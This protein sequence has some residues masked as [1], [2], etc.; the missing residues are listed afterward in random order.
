MAEDKLADWA[1]SAEGVLNSRTMP[2]VENA[3]LDVMACAI[4]G[5]ADPS[6]RAVADL[7]SRM[8]SGT[9]PTLGSRRANAAPWAAM[10]G[11]TAA[12][13]LD[14]D[15]NFAPAT[16]HA[17]A[18]LVPALFALAGEIGSSGEQLAT[19]YIVGLEIQARIGRALNPGHYESGWHATSTIG[20]IGGAGACSRLLGLNGDETLAALSAAASMASGSKKQ[21]GTMMK[22]AHAGLAAKNSV[23]A[24]RMAQAGLRGDREPIFG[25]WSL[26]E[27]YGGPRDDAFAADQIDKDLGAKLSIVEDGL[28]Q[29]RFPCCGA[30]HR[31]LDGLLALRSRHQLTIE[32]IERVDAFV[33]AFARAN[34]LYDRPKNASEARFSLTYC[35]ARILQKG[36]LTLSDLTDQSV[37]EP[38][39]QE[40]LERVH[41]QTKPGSVVEELGANAT[42]ARTRITLKNGQVIETDISHVRGSN[43]D[44]LSATETRAKF[45]DC[46]RFAG[47]TAAAPALY[48]LTG[49][50]VGAPDLRALNREFE[51]LIGEAPDAVGQAS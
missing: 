27:L 2:L 33:P 45:I 12:H 4:A 49:K 1:A 9:A 37:S 47:H 5:A 13:A 35:G 31:T 19:A 23:L 30:A 38:Q 44:P 17:S 51:A 40:W 46:C 41:V 29:K 50:I 15:D 42:P 24:A 34:L 18:V 14:F 32:A 16:T 6:A 21:F 11:G 26:S 20:V 48:E 28:L 3:L 25:A 7:C 36:D 10:A 8:G 39:I 43:V 22:S